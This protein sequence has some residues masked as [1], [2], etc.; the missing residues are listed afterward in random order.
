[1]ASRFIKFSFAT[2]LVLVS[3]SLLAQQPGQSINDTIK[4]KTLNVE[5]KPEFKGIERLGDTDG[6]VITAGKKNEVI[7]VT[8]TDANTAVN[9]TRQTFA[10]VPGLMIWENDGTGIQ[11]G[12]STRGLSP[13]R[14]WEF[15]NRQNG[16]DISAD[17]FGYP[18]AYYAPP[19]EFLQSVQFVRGAASLQFGP[20]FGGLVNYVFKK[21]DTAAISIESYQTAGSYGVF[22]SA[23]ILS[24]TKG[25]LSYIGMFNHRNAD[26]WRN[27]SR[28]NYNTGYGAIYYQPTKTIRLKAE[29]TQMGFLSQQAGGLTDSMFAVDARQSFRSRNWLNITWKM[30]SVEFNYDI[31]EQLTLNIKAFALFG[32]RE[33]I[34]FTGNIG[35]T[36]GDLNADPLT[37][38]QVDTDNY[39]NYG[40]EARILYNYKLF[41][42]NHTLAGGLRYSTGKTTRIRYIGNNGTDAD[43]TN[44]FADSLQRDFEFGTTNLAA[45]AENIFKLGK[46]LTITPGIRFEY[47]SNT[48][49]FV[50]PVIFQAN[51][52]RQFP[53]VGIGI[54]Y[55]TGNTNNVY[56]NFSQ[57]FRPVL[58]GDITP[59][60]T[61]DVIDPNLKDATGY[62]AD[63][64]WRGNVSSWLNYDVSLFYL[65]YNNRTGR[66]TLTD[67]SGTY[68]YVTNLTNSRTMGAEFYVE[69]NPVKLIKPQT[70]WGSI[71][72]F[73]A[74]TIQNA[75]YT[76]G[77]INGGT[78]TEVNMDGKKVEYAPALVIRSGINYSY[79]TFSTSLQVSHTGKVYADANNTETA[80]TGN[81]GLVPA[82]TV[83]DWSAS[84][85]LKSHYIIKGGINNLFNQRYFTRRA[86]GYPG[87]GILPADGR[88]FYITVGAKF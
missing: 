2:T 68:Q 20:Q 51:T 36:N 47:L 84:I 73:T 38:R 88:T 50:R 54:G 44:A 87:P 12:I 32:D 21:P 16:Y 24:G 33:S 17:P 60:A 8:K 3:C 78:N 77:L 57:A 13:N 39:T 67:S 69:F 56:A 27:N 5:S 85:T 63:L 18:E 42:G 15:N 59:A 43:F 25:K 46:R 28:Y 61:T 80:K 55:K 53:L 1:M 83:A 81:T 49:N 48:G 82:Y 58:Y 9:N 79:K 66:L 72:L 10:K 22:N 76:K 26:G 11:V 37:N 41:G 40:A 86:G 19:F 7:D 23:T 64:G 35:K 65:Q 45:F 52:K 14:S 6:T 62:T 31:N 34:G 75:E 30:P 29:Y 74:G 4:L 71:S 70:R